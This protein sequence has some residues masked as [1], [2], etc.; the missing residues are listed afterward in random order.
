M[1]EGRGRARAKIPDILAF[2]PVSSSLPPTGMTISGYTKYTD[3]DDTDTG[4][5]T[6]T[7]SYRYID[8][9]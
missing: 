8:V 2:D 4:T 5:G 7:D 6:D 3:I 1:L 9:S